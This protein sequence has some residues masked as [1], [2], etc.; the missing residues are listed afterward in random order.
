MQT[1]GVVIEAYHA[2]LSNV[3]HFREML[4]RSF[5]LNDT[6]VTVNFDRGS[7]GQMPAAHHSPIGAY[8]PVGDKVL[9]MDVARYKYPPVWCPVE[10]LF[11][12]MNTVWNPLTN[13]TRGF[14]VVYVND[15]ASVYDSA[16]NSTIFFVAILM[17]I[18][19]FLVGAV[20]GGVVIGIIFKRKMNKLI[21]EDKDSITRLIEE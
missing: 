12:A 16:D 9:I 10:L 17:L 19:L 18:G 7:I 21:E 14:L 3:T 8:D 20:V 13:E 2:R 11:G 15:R 4:L 5:D 6:F 1:W